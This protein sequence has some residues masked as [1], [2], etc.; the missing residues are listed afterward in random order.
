MHVLLVGVFPPLFLLAA[1]LHEF[2]TAEALPSVACWLMISLTC[3]LV[4][5]IFIG[6]RKGAFVV[7]LFIIGLC[8]YRHVLEITAGAPGG[9]ALYGTTVLLLAVF[10]ASVF[11][12]VKTRKNLINATK[13]LNLVAVS[14]FAQAAVKVAIHEISL[15]APAKAGQ[16]IRAGESAPLACPERAPNVYLIIL[17]GYGRADNLLNLYGHDNTA[18]TEDLRSKG[19][20][21][22]Q[23]SRSNYSHTV[24]ALPSMLNFSH[25]KDPALDPHGEGN[26][27]WTEMTRSSRAAALFKEMGYRVVS[28]NGSK[29]IAGADLYMLP[30]EERGFHDSMMTSLGTVLPSAERARDRERIRFVFDNLPSTAELEG[31]LFVY[32]HV[33]APHPPFVFSR[34]G[35]DPGGERY[36]GTGSASHV[37]KPGALTRAQYIQMYSAQLSYLNELVEASVEALLGKSRIEPII[38][39]HGDHGPGAYLHHEDINRTYLQDR[40]SILS[41]YHFP[42]GGDDILYDSI[43]PVN[44]F[45]VIFNRYFS[46]T[47]ELLEDESC[48][49]TVDKPWAFTDVTQDIDSPADRQ[50][51]DALKNADYYP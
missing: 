31:P 46:G 32:A 16:L 19:F 35:G 13:I 39:I 44:T 47:F 26:E 11:L 38:V 29:E 15:G 42:Q 24:L 36:F 2:R 41:A 49:T 51:L 14:L 25:L 20:Y 5:A 45:R 4:L 17:D 9:L 43:S 6:L 30:R 48:F 21:V 28:F 22:A 18:F 12:L 33:M 40:M 37:I 7:S 34:S 1:N 23:D 3:S 8:S 50:R 10:G 27:N